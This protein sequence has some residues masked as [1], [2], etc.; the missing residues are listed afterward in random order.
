M[1]G[2][3]EEAKDRQEGQSGHQKGC[4]NFYFIFFNLN[5]RDIV[6]HDKVDMN[7]MNAKKDNKNH[8]VH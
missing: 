3:K 2:T 4:W 5:D 6:N 7:A 8:S 1:E